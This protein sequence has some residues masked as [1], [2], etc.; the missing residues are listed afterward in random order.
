MVKTTGM[1][2]SYA[3]SM[4][5]QDGLEA[6]T[7]HLRN[8]YSRDWA[9]WGNLKKTAGEKIQQSFVWDMRMLIPVGGIRLLSNMPL[10]VTA[11]GSTCLI[12]GKTGKIKMT[13]N[14]GNN[15]ICRESVPSRSEL[16]IPEQPRE[17]LCLNSLNKNN[18]SSFKL[19]RRI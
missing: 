12:Q 15:L 5:P 9:I 16:F 11:L 7:Y 17:T 1:S 8:S 13:D 14:H 2:V 4:V 10:I 18:E 3:W 19:L 6:P